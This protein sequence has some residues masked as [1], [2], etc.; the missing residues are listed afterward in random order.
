MVLEPKDFLVR[1]EEHG[2]PQRR[3]RVFVICMR[4]DVA[5]AL[6]EGMFPKLKPR[7]EQVALSDVVGEMP[8]LRSRLSRGDDGGAWQSAV[9]DAYGLVGEHLPETSQ[10]KERKFRSALKLALEVGK[11]RASPLPRPLGDWCGRR[12]RLLPREPPGL[13]LR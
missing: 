7:E 12:S 1:A 3:H 13:V 5:A 9:E 11:R 2:V 8:Q 6:P 4:T 10:S